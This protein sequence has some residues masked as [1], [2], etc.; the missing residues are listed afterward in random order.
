MEIDSERSQW[1]LRPHGGFPGWKGGFLY[2]DITSSSSSCYH[3]CITN[4]PWLCE[5]MESKNISQILR[6]PT[7]SQVERAPLYKMFLFGL[8]IEGWLEP[9]LLYEFPCQVHN[10]PYIGVTGSAW[11]APPWSQAPFYLLKWPKTISMDRQT[12]RLAIFPGILIFRD[13]HSFAMAMMSKV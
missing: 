13:A 12:P 3:L 10:F 7:N 4:F 2:P 11:W 1:H 5:I 8:S 6:D 9:K